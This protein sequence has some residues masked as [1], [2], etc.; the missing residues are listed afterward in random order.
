MGFSVIP[1][2]AISG[3][4]GPPGPAGTI[5]SDPTFDGSASINDTTGDPDFNLKKNGSLRWKVRSAGTESGSNNGSDL[6]VEAFADDGTTKIGDPL[7][8]SR[9]GTQVTVGIANS[10]QS[11]VKL[12][13]NGAVGL[14][15]TTDPATSTIGPQL[16]SK[17]GKLWVQT[18]SG[19]EKFQVV[20]SLPKNGNAQLNGQYMWLD[21]AAGT[22]R[23]FGY[24]TAGVD[25]WL[26]QVDDI[27]ESGSAAGSNFRLS[28]RNDDGSFNKTV[29]YARR[30][31]GQIVF[32]TTTLHGS[33]NV[34]SAGAIGI[35]DQ[36]ADPATATGGV[37]LYSK[38]GVAYVKQG[39]GTV[40]QLGA[41]G[42]GGTVSS[43]NG[44]TGVVA[45]AA[46]DVGALPATGGTLSGELGV[47]G[48]AGTYREFSFKSGGVKRW[49]LQADNTAEPA[50]GTGSDFRIFSRN[51]DGTFNLN[52]LSISR[53]W[54]QTTFGD[55]GPL[56]DAKATTSG[57]HG[58]RNMAYEP[59]LPNEGAL[60][61]A[62]NSLPYI[63]QGDG[64][65]FRLSPRGN[66]L[67]PEDIG[68]AA[69][70]SNPAACQSTGAYSGT[71]NARVTGVYLREPKSISKI[72]WHFRGYAGGLLANSW[73]AVYTSSGTRVL[74]NDAIHTGT[75][76]PATVATAGGDAAY[77]PVTPTVLQPGLYYIVWRFVYTTS[78]V[79]GP[80]L[81]QYENSAAA[82]PNSFGLT[83]TRLFGVYDASSQNTS[84]T[85]LTVSSMQRS[86]NR[87]WAALA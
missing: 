46:S 82:P 66:E 62:R 65:V 49:S 16:Y 53:K 24:K 12:S 87:F 27:A 57:A 83:N 71:T 80:E 55:N 58:L 60:L 13:V 67:Q 54:A 22:Y 3:F 42:G 76:E 56:G 1:E 23:A 7:W 40:F 68:L 72:V 29:I 35:R 21:T 86:A 28:A 17:A 70:S 36:A 85:S 2:P 10:S 43:V 31:T 45:L 52:G 61:Y 4:T 5:P 48:A 44:K 69:W 15:D 11:G 59:A 26:M 30:D 18:A 50:D 51:N 9:T 78:P 20:E 39:D 79:D 38:G 14:R 77:V 74:F 63:K 47:D 8:I 33:A 6:W 73:V 34:T 32:N 37:F 84:Y 81:L 25:R 64:T 41:G 75:N 19:A